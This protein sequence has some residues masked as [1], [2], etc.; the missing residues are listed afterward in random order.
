MHRLVA[1][2]NEPARP[3]HPGC[4][5]ANREQQ[6]VQMTVH[7]TRKGRLAGK[8][9]PPATEDEGEYLTARGVGDGTG[10]QRLDR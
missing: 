7:R 3:S 10:P 6:L 9:G 1:W 5:L 4:D 8:T 2:C